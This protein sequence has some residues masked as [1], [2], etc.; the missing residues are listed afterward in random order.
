MISPFTDPWA[1][2]IT[3]SSR[4][5]SANGTNESGTECVAQVKAPRGSEHLPQELEDKR[6]SQVETFTISNNCRA[7]WTWTRPGLR[8]HSEM[9]LTACTHVPQS[10]TSGTLW[11]SDASFR[12][13]TVFVNAVPTWASTHPF[14]HNVWAIFFSGRPF[15]VLNDGYSCPKERDVC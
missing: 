8:C 4:C 12:L 1:C 9:R 13:A 10:Q 2:V 5:S 7:C 6:L 14:A 11:R 15:Y 3:P